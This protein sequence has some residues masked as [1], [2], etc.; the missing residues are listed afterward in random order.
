MATKCPLTLAQFTAGAQALTVAF[1]DQKRL[2]QP[3]AFSSGSLGWGVNDKVILDVGGVPVTCQVSLSLTVVGS[4]GMALE[5]SEA[6]AAVAP[7]VQEAVTAV[8]RVQE[9]TNGTPGKVKLAK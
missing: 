6:P 1:G 2:A 9:R 4:K 5:Q 7:V 3:R 8:N